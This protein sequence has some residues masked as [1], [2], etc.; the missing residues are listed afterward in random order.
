MLPED[1]KRSKVSMP[2]MDVA[3]FNAIVDAGMHKQYMHNALHLNQGNLFFSDI[4]QFS[5]VAKTEWSWSCLLADFDNDGN[6]DIFVANG[7]KRDVFDGD[8]QQKLATF[9]NNNR[10]KYQ[11]PQEMLGKDFKGFIDNYSPIKVKNYLFKNKGDL[12]FENVG[13]KWGFTETSFSNG[14]AIGD[15]D[16]DGDVDMVINNLD[17]EAFIYENTSA[18]R[19]NYLKMKLVGPAGNAD[20]I[21]AKVTAYYEG[22]IQYFENK[23]VRGYLSSNDPIVHF[24]LGKI[25]TIDSVRVV[26]SD[27]KE[28]VLR[29]IKSNQMIKVS[30]TESKTPKFKVEG[31]QV[32][33]ESDRLSQR[34]MLIRTEGRITMRVGLRGSRGVCMFKEMGSSLKKKFKFSSMIKPSK[35]W[36]QPSLMRNRME[37]SICMS[38]AEEVSFQRVPFSIRIGFT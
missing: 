38:L 30:Y 35:T 3:G 7:Y 17:E 5:G 33:R 19:N 9:V 20:G 13:D 31:K 14:A 27:G 16:N 12:Q 34:E 8:V 2:S 15:L 25:S 37:T 1:Y 29:S 18:E 36:V 24:G 11:S 23:T 26:W 10:S 6:R 22:K 32:F 4:S 21:G 28:N